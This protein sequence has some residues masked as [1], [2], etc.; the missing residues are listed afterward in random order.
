MFLF[1]L[2][3]DEVYTMLLL[4]DFFFFKKKEQFTVS[5]GAHIFTHNDVQFDALLPKNSSEVSQ[6]SRSEHNPFYTLK[7]VP[8]RSS[9]TWSDSPSR[10]R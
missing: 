4:L 6:L 7:I 10:V 9:M 1:S 8:A 3:L 5:G 2:N